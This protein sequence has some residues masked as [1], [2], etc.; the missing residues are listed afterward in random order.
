MKGLAITNIGIEDV[1]SSEIKELTGAKTK[2]E[3]GF[4][5][6]ERT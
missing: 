1:T 5:V 3:P 4:V 6:F 2:A